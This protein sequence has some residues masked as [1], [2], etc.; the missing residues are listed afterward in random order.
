[1]SSE[2]P[3]SK[4]LGI[5]DTQFAK[6][7]RVKVLNKTRLYV[8]DGAEDLVGK[9]GVII[10][11]PKYVS[12]SAFEKAYPVKFGRRKEWFIGACLRKVKS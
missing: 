11:E 9:V 8:Y 7:E 10:G 3:A 6:G 1:M 4:D 12:G 2:Q 5:A